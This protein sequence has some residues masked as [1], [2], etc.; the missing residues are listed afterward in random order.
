MVIDHSKWTEDI[1]G[2]FDKKTNDA[3]R[4]SC[5]VGYLFF[6]VPIIMHPESKF[7][8]YHTN[9]SL[10]LLILSMV[11]T[12]GLAQIPYAG[13][14]LAILMLLFCLIFMIRGIILSL[15]GMAKHVPF[16]GK[17]VIVEF[18]NFYS[19]DS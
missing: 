10:I 14:P 11:G 16:F 19:L 1:A 4:V 5:A 17:L 6:F 2:R 15:R 9:Q 18:D 3:A 7:A 12:L 8:R 13:P